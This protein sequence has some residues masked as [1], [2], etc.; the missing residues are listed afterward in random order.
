MS[1]ARL[2]ALR[3]HRWQSPTLRELV[4]HG[5]RFGVDC[6]YETAEGMHAQGRLD[7]L[8]LGRLARHLRRID[9]GWRLAADQ[10]ERLVG[11]LREQGISNRDVADMAGVSLSTVT[12]AGAEPPDPDPQKRMVEPQMSVKSRQDRSLAVCF[13]FDASASAPPPPVEGTWRAWVYGGAPI[14][15][16]GDRRR[17]SGRVRAQIRRAA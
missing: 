15:H 17:S 4:R 10:R 1:S 16:V 9:R 6:V 3:T 7:A 13:Q 14:Q 11:L 12:R 2:R 5:E 8:E